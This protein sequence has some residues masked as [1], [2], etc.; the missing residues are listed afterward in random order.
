MA[1]AT[2]LLR[3]AVTSTDIDLH[4]VTAVISDDPELQEPLAVSYARFVLVGGDGVRLHEEVLHAGGWVRPD[5]RFA[6]VESF[7]RLDTQLTAALAQGH[8]APPQWQHR[9]AQGWANTEN[10]LFLALERRARE[11]SITL[12][13]LLSRRQADERRRITENLDRFGAA[14]RGR[15]AAADDED[16][17]L[18]LFAAEVTDPVE[19]AQLRRDQQSWRRRLDTL[20]AELDT[21]LHRISARYADPADHLFPVAVVFVIPRRDVTR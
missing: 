2:R 6:R 19:S 3:A 13:N 14:L 9:L 16:T 5:G 8:P 4:R 12:R 17:E 15:L 1:R 20:P 11:R 18:A 21:E 7:A 10:G